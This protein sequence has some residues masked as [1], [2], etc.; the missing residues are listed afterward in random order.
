MRYLQCD[1]RPGPGIDQPGWLG[2]A[3]AYHRRLLQQDQSMTE[4]APAPTAPQRKD[5]AAVTDESWSDERVRSF[6]HKDTRALPG[7]TDFNLLLHAFQS[8]REED[9]ARFLQ[10]FVAAGHDLDAPDQRGWT[11]VEYISR[12]RK[13]APF[14]QMLLAAGAR[15]PVAR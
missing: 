2:P 6:L 1:K 7:S 15:T 10:F 3:I 12:Y 14:V 4:T 5:K 8:M 13:A 11:F 9:F